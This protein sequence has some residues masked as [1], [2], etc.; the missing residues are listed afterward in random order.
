M[1]EKQKPNAKLIRAALATL[2]EREAHETTN[3]APWNAGAADA[4][5]WVMGEYPGFARRVLYGDDATDTPPPAP[6]AARGR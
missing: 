4:L 2:N 6:Y 3:P 1:S 5:A